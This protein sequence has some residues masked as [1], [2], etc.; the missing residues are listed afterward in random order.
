MDRTRQET[1]GRAAATGAAPA[2]RAGTISIG[3][4]DVARLGYGAMRL[5]G[6]QIWGPPEDRDGAHRLLRLAVEELG[7]TLIDTADAYGPDVNEE[8]IREALHPY[9]EGVLIATKGGSVRPGPG[10]WERNG[11][12]EHLRRALEGSLRRLKVDRVDL[13]QHHAPDPDVPIEDSLGELRRLQEEGKIRHVGVSNYDVEKLERARRV[14]EVVSVQNLYNVGDR[15]S[16]PVVDWCEANGVAFMAYR[17][18]AGGEVAGPALERVAERHGATT[19]QVGLAWLL[20]RSP[21]VAPIPGTSSEEH[22]KENVAASGL[23]L[24]EE[25]MEALG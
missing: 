13:Y 15:R 7:V 10:K 8:I 20:H 18:V 23:V 22:L 6:P 9:P 11:R 24:S 21:A 19:F 17:P 5:T 12:P 25:D 2:A 1:A 3:D 16:D 4:L 14:V